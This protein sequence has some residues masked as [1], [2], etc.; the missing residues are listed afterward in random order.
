VKQCERGNGENLQSAG[1]YHQLPV[2]GPG[3]GFISL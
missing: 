3:C 1:I 2:S